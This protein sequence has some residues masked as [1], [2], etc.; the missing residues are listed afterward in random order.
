MGRWVRRWL[1]GLGTL[2][3]VLLV[4]LVATSGVLDPEGGV[5]RA[6]HRGAGDPHVPQDARVLEPPSLAGMGEAVEGEAREGAARA[7]DVTGPPAQE[8]SSSSDPDP[9]LR[10]LTVRVRSQA[11]HPV[12]GVR[13]HIQAISQDPWLPGGAE[14]VTPSLRTDREGHA[15]FEIPPGST[16]EVH[17][18][19]PSPWLP[20]DPFFAVFEEGV[21]EV[22]L[23]EGA[24][25]QG[26]VLD[27]RGRRAPGIPVTITWVRGVLRG[28]VRSEA[29]AKGTFRGVVP[30]DAGEIVAEV[31]DVPA[32]EEGREHP[33]EAGARARVEGL[34]PGARDVVL[35]LGDAAELSGWCV[36]PDG[37]VLRAASLLVIPRIGPATWASHPVDPQTGRFHV[38]GLRHVPYWVFVRGLPEGYLP[39]VPEPIP[40]PAKDV[41]L[42]CSGGPG[43]PLPFV[44]GTIEGQDL[45]GFRATWLPHERAW[46]PKPASDVRPDGTF[47]IERLP[48]GRGALLVNREGD[49]LHAWLADADPAEGPFDLRLERGKPIHG[50][51]V[52]WPG[53]LDEL[54]VILSVPTGRDRRQRVDED[55]RFR[56]RGLPPGDYKLR[57]TYRLVPEGRRPP[58]PRTIHLVDVR[59]SEREILLDLGLD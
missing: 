47:R 30:R 39:P 21:V 43:A 25:V 26:I 7:E 54:E 28:L 16:I 38:Q 36:G 34:R 17:A 20:P 4:V 58:M 40:M 32:P 44:E 41:R 6:S 55:G 29:D 51:V 48:P 59:P 31:R 13:V 8:A 27:C 9:A 42:V 45:T 11:G 5:E 12:A 22:V 49:D 37:E 35:E 14:I 18:S 33:G 3:A 56:F 1:L 52:G 46:S 15:T 23:L 50:R 53:A 2:L 19:P 57:T 24:E 10:T